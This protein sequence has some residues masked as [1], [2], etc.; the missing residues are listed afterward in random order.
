MNKSAKLSFVFLLTVFLSFGTSI[1]QLPTVDWGLAFNPTTIGMV[2]VKKIYEDPYINDVYM[3]GKFSGTIDFDPGTGTAVKPSQG[4]DDVFVVKINKYGIFQWCAT[5]GGTS[6]DVGYDLTTDYLGNVFVT[7]GFMNTVDFDPGTGTS[8]QVSNGQEDYFV[9]KL[10]TSG[11]FGWVYTAGG[12]AMDIGKGVS[13]DSSGNI[14][15]AGRAGESVDWN[16]GSGA[17]TLFV[18]GLSDGFVHKISPSGNYVW[19][20]PIGGV[21]VD[22]ALGVVATPSY[23]VVVTGFSKA[24]DYDFGGGVQFKADSG[25]YVLRLDSSGAFIWVQIFGGLWSEPKRISLDVM[26]NIFTS[27]RFA[28]TI[29]MDPG[30]ATSLI[31]MPFPTYGLYVH[32]MDSNGNFDWAKAIGD[33][34]SNP[35][36]GGMAVDTFGNAY[37]AGDFKDSMDLDPGTGVMM[38]YSNGGGLDNFAIKLDDNGNHIY[39]FRLG[40][41]PAFYADIPGDIA[42]GEDKMMYLGGTYNGVPDVNP[43]TDT[44]VVTCTLLSGML[45][46]Y[47]ECPVVYGSLVD[48]GCVSYTV[49]GFMYLTSGVYMQY[50]S[51]ADN[52]DSILTVDVTII[53]TSNF[54]FADSGCVSYFF[55]GQNLTVTGTY[56]DTLVAASGCDSL[57]SLSLEM[58]IPDTNIA[59]QSA[60]APFNDSLWVTVLTGSE[61]VQWVNC[62]LGYVPVSGATMQIFTPLWSANYA[63]IVSEGNCSDTSSCRFAFGPLVY[64]SDQQNASVAMY[65]NPTTGQVNFDFGLHKNEFTIEVMDLEGRKLMEKSGRNSR[66]FEFK[67]DNFAGV[68]I[69]KVETDGLQKNLFLVKE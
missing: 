16:P 39:S 31:S 25:Q 22:E 37:L 68:Y 41:V 6:N 29:D 5:F 61:T 26:G 63:A 50:L 15:T 32:K 11:T 13:C 53:P 46:K 66:H 9:L 59:Y 52:C 34:S 23:R 65:P 27:G 18:T 7:G 30:P 36:W 12:V 2:T 33:I 1:A 17:D 62:D 24:T 8:T 60:T 44:T 45:V 54:G 40:D 43:G 55:N 38:H 49:N 28:D 47:D 67:L 4:S 14:Y 19:A 51:S 58:V 69:V 57:I 20:Y 21:F 48:T 10:T 42:A 64:L 35:T 56:Y 3:T